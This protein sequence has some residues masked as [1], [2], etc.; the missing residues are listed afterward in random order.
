MA[1]AAPRPGLERP[2][3][4][5]AGFEPAEAEACR[6]LLG[7]EAGV[8]L[9]EAADAASAADVE[10]EV[11]RRLER[12]QVAVLCLGPGLSG[13]KARHLLDAAVAAGRAP[14]LSLLTA[15]GPDPTLFQELIDDDRIFYLSAAPVPLG[16]LEA[17]LR[18]AL[19][20]SRALSGAD[21]GADAAGAQPQEHAAL[22][23]RTLA[24]ARQVAAQ[25]DLAGCC[26]VLREAAR[27]LAA[28]DRA[29]ALLYDPESETLWSREPGLAA[30]ERRESAAVGLVSFVARTGRAVAVERLAED[31]RYEREADDPAGRGEERFLAVPVAGEHG[32]VL[33][34]LSAVRGPERPPFSPGDREA[35]ALLAEHVA[36]PLG[37]LVEEQRLAAA[38]RR[39]EALLRDRSLDLFR[40]EALDHHTAGQLHEGDLLRLSPRWTRWT[41]RLLLAVLAAG[42]L[43]LTFGRLD[44]YAAGPA[45]VRFAGLTE[46]TAN[47][48]GIIEEVAVR[49]GQR[50][51]AGDLLVRFH[52]AEEIAERNR[53]EREF[54]LRLIDRL[55]NPADPTAAQALGALRADRERAE[56]RLGERVVRAP[57]PGLVSDVRVRPGR[58]VAPGQVLL[59]LAG[60]RARP[61]VA[62]LLPGQDRPLLAP[63]LRLRLELQGYAYSYQHLTVAAVGEEV[64]GPEEARRYL[65]PEIADAVPIEGPVVLVYADLPALTFEADGR[66]YRFHDGMW[67]RAEVKVRSERIFE[68]LVPGVKALFGDGSP[69]GGG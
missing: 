22:A 18:G 44:D 66:T 17:L 30:E 59:S 23:R 1:T 41:Y 52:R 13:L 48:P 38:D 8:H 3:V 34:V 24:V 15:A 31:P 62:A 19:E 28:A 58:P 5:L 26:E 7:D 29:S 56:A 11:L 50:V 6:R 21:P 46:V 36:T 51:A 45:V 33:A 14:A 57:A 25:G 35:V 64:V 10:R 69:R 37:Q 63:G 60:G 43:Y 9:V 53:I 16:D 65:G 55:R 49:P 4:L 20:R 40:E 32:R 68:A 42:I 39:R 61:R 2:L 54:E 27:S 12:E 67:G 47:A